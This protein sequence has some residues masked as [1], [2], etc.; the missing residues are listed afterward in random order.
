MQDRARHDGARE[1]VSFRVG[2]QEFCFDI[3]RVREIRGWTPATPL[4]HTPTYVRGVVNLRGAV[5]PIVEVAERLGMRGSEPTTQHVII[6]TQ[7]GNQVVGL[8]VTAVCDILIATDQM[9][10]SVPDTAFGSGD[11]VEGLVTYD[12]RML[13]ILDTERLIPGTELAEAA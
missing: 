9:I 4:P 7:C 11:F 10:Q 3:H 1:M 5:L 2:E 12:G 6:V 8:L 13:S